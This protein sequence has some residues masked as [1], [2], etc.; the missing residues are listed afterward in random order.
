MHRRQAASHHSQVSRSEVPLAIVHCDLHGPMPV[1]SPEGCRFF[2]V[3]VDDAT[4][5][6]AVY[7]LKHKSNA[8]TAFWT[9]RAA[10]ENA[11]GRRI[12]VLHDDK[13]GGLSSNE[14]NAE[15]Q[16]SGISLH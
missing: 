9:F 6:W 7:F 15:L 14:F 12:K 11:T 1:H 5:L 3:F 16:E 4:R 8:P 10:M 13:E 2:V